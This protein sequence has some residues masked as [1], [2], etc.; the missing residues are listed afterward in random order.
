MINALSNYG[1]YGVALLVNLFLQ[2]YI[3]RS[4]GSA[5]Y[6][7]WPL[8]TTV[9]GFISLIPLAISG[10]VNRYLAHA[11]ARKSIK[12]VEQ[13]T[14]SVFY[15]TLVGTVIYTVAVVGFS[16]SFERIFNIPEAAAGIGIWVMLLV[17]VAQAFKVPVSVFQGGLNAA[18]K[19]IALN[20]REIAVQVL[21]GAL[22]VVAFV[23][24]GASL[25]W[26]AIAWAVTQL[27]GAF[28]TWTIAWRL[29]PWQRLRRDGF[30][31]AVLRKVLGFG[32]WVLIGTIASFLYWRTGNI[33]I[34]KLLDPILLTGYS[35]VVG[36][37]LQG[38]QLASLGSGVLFSAATVLHARRDV[39]RMARMTYRAS[40]VTTALAAPIVL[41]LA[42]F[43]SPVMT[44]YLGDVHFGEY[45]IYFAVLGAA[46][47]IQMT[48]I[49]SRTVPQAY[50]RNAA[51]NLVALAAAA[52]NV[53]MALLLI[54]GFGWGLMGVAASA[55]IV[56]ALFN[57]CFLPWYS[58]RLLQ[59][60]W[61]QHFVKSTLLPIAH[62]LPALA[63][64]A[65]FWA[66]GFGQTLWQLIVVLVVTLVVHGAYMVAWG[67]PT[68]DRKSVVGWV[69]RMTSLAKHAQRPR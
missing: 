3:I 41:F 24:A 54:L 60:G 55:A 20:L 12:E 14:T 61:W 26:V 33:I 43:G 8:A 1:R 65:I 30:D 2:A 35:V 39:D 18:Q 58:A 42:F 44:I 21:Y 6:S 9:T 64:L 7:I 46:L 37:L 66:T 63:V 45:G 53:G 10:G 29:L 62:C 36:I 32:L 15:A 5:E 28:F 52:A 49:P 59:V 50:A 47:L 38:Y 4:V 51:N 48:Q 23:A 19:F 69:K 67:L 56:I 31:W 25:L 57:A 16:L 34:N 40:R 11:F 27:I 13:I 22:V 68:E 17:G